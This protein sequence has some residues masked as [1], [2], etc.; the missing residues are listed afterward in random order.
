[1][2]DTSD[3]RTYEDQIASNDNVPHRHSAS[4]MKRRQ[5]ITLWA[6]IVIFLIILATAIEALITFNQAVSIGRHEQ[7]AYEAVSAIRDTAEPEIERGDIDSLVGLFDSSDVKTLQSETAA[8]DRIAHDTN[9]SFLAHL[10]FARDDVE[11][12]QALTGAADTL[13]HQILADYRSAITP[14]A[15]LADTDFSSASTGSLE[16]LQQ[17]LSSA[18]TASQGSIGKAARELKAQSDR[19]A[20]APR[21]HFGIINTATDQV[22]SAFTEAMHRTQKISVR[23]LAHGA[24]VAKL[25]AAGLPASLAQLLGL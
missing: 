19:L 22:R 9:W 24:F 6:I 15:P 13:S 20:S 4:T 25:T 12:V 18:L 8:A 5:R 3:Y 10:S 14:W 11:A 2:T 23:R 17:R 16:S 1:M 21:S 7:R